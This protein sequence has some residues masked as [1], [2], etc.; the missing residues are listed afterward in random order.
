[1]A[2]RSKEATDSR[3]GA[4]IYN[5]TV[6]DKV[7]PVNCS[8]A[9][10]IPYLVLQS[11]SGSQTYTTLYNFYNLLDANADDNIWKRLDE[12]IDTANTTLKF[13]E[14]VDWDIFM[15]AEDEET[16]ERLSGD[17]TE[18][19]KY[20]ISVVYAGVVFDNLYGVDEKNASTVPP[21]IRMRL[22][23]NST[24]VHDTTLMR[25]K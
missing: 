4:Y 14:V 16:I 6:D 2:N 22:R 21:K 3:A 11:Q 7:V 25:Q 8:A 10:Y 23:L 17:Y 15:P 20:N 13:I 18:R 9:S 24:F 12:V 19:Q 1:M 5:M